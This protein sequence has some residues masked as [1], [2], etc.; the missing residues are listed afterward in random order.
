MKIFDQIESEVRPYART[1][2]RLFHKAAGERLYDEERQG[3]KTDENLR[4]VGIK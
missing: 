3:V 2:P 4:P 1:F